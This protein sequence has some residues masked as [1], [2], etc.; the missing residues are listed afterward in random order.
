MHEAGCD[1]STYPRNIWMIDFKGFKGRAPIVPAI[2]AALPPL[3]TRRLAGQSTTGAIP[4]E[5]SELLV[6]KRARP[7]KLQAGS[8]IANTET[9]AGVDLSTLIIRPRVPANC[10]SYGRISKNTAEASGWANRR[11]GGLGWQGKLGDSGLGWQIRLLGGGR[12][13]TSH[14]HLSSTI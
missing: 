4:F 12:F 10:V 13:S 11:A 8:G 7:L 2:P 14:V 3:S 9:Q 6:V 1:G 5:A